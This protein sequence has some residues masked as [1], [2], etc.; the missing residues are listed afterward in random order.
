MEKP[1]KKGGDLK[2]K[3]A[4]PSIPKTSNHALGD[5][6]AKVQYISEHPRCDLGV[7]LSDRDEERRA[8]HCRSSTMAQTVD[9]VVKSGYRFVVRR[10]LT[11]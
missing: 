3:L 8:Y 5:V 7:K 10:G 4:V 2:E 9:G 11:E 6:L 1:C